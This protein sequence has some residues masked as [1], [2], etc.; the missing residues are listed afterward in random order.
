MLNETYLLRK[1][2]DRAELEIPREHPRVKLPGNSAGPCLRIRLDEQAHVQ[3]V[4]AVTEA[5][6]PGL[7]TVMEG[8]QNSFPVVRVKNPLCD[9]SSDGEMWKKLGFDAQ[10]RRKNKASDNDRLSILSATLENH[11]KLSEN[12]DQLFR[13]LQ[14]KAKELFQVA[15][16]ES[17]ESRIL[18][19]FAR[20]FQ[21]AANTP[22]ILLREI[23]EHALTAVQSARLD[24]L[25]TVETFLVGKGP[26]NDSGNHPT[27]AVQLAFDL[28]DIPA[29]SRRLYSHQICEHVKRALPMERGTSQD[30]HP[31]RECAYTGKEQ[32]LQVS[33]FPKVRL[34]VLNKDFPL[35]SMF[36][37][38]ACNQRYGLTDALIVPVA[39][40]VALRMQDAL[41]WIVAQERKGKT[42][43]PVASGKFDAVRG[44]KK[45]RSDLLIIYVDGNPQI[46]VNVAD[47]FG[48][49]EG[50]QQKQFQIDA[51]AV[52]DALDGISMERPG[53]KLNIFLL[54]KASEGQ[55]HVVVAESPSVED[56]LDAAERWQQAATNVPRV[57]LPLPGE[58]GEA[59]V[60]TE[61]KVPYPDQVVRLLSEEWV[62]NGL[63]SNKVSSI[64]LGE[65]LDLMLHTP[66]KWEYSTRH[67]LDL[68]VR[69]L[70]PLLL[71]IFGAL[72]MGE[73][74]HL[75]KY[76][77]KSRQIGLRTVSTFG[78][79]LE[80]IGRL[81]ERYMN[82]TAFLVGRLLS[83]AD[84]LHR[85][86]CKHVRDDKIPPQLIGN[87]LMPVA[88]DNPKDA[89]DR[90][91]ERIMIYKAWADKGNGAEF[92]LAKWTVARIGE[93]CSQLSQ[94]PLCPATDQKFRAELFLGYM[95]RLSSE[96]NV[97][98]KGLDE[99]ENNDVDSK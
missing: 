41:T 62:A 66:G 86:Y 34:P 94:L 95:S 17:S 75:N 49:D 51:Q 72:N 7:W 10:G 85:E 22:K 80:A 2:L 64:G 98:G 77:K 14:D 37:E 88:A 89:L 6:R 28:H 71:G 90:L 50:E 96:K 59:A 70:G 83:L 27:M 31:A 52:C 16:D 57:T 63:R 54:R 38:A 1:A 48:T 65:V 12:T 36:S 40:E 23:G 30:Q 5:E 69:R 58:E 9:V 78:I 4:E 25:D 91:R 73:R 44:R 29:F 99:E 42:W 45:E 43:R 19:E 21:K 13:R 35:V 92:R 15:D 47:F 61:P 84:I 55:A 97:D 8:N 24:S 26:P 79:L 56:I 39:K 46:D 93:I 81:K 60:P 68:T 32:S 53:S 76:R 20:R 82:D 33:T 3:A 74:D 18:Q 87:A 67:M 11:Y